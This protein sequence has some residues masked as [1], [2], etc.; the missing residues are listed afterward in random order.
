MR[1]LRN[2]LVPSLLQL[3]LPPNPTPI[4]IKIA[5]RPT[6]L[7]NGSPTH[8]EIL[9]HNGS[10]TQIEMVLLDANY[11]IGLDTPPMF[12]TLKPKPTMKLF[13]YCN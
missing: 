2:Y 12:I 4:I 11:V 3:L 13:Y 9:H 5:V 10:Q 7:N 8:V 6:I 1:M